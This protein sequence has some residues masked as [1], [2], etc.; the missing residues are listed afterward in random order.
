MATLYQGATGHDNTGGLAA[1]DPQP[2]SDGLQYG[3]QTG[4]S[5]TKQKFHDS[6]DYIDLRYSVATPAEGY[7]ILDTFGLLV[8]PSADVTVT[9][10]DTI[11]RDD[12]H[13]YNGIAWRPDLR[14]RLWYHDFNIHVTAL[15][16]IT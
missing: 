6:D 3:R 8:D 7:D 12:F 4:V 15:E 11:M 16:I 5:G 13:D 2:A 14:Y 10:P 9:I 1:L